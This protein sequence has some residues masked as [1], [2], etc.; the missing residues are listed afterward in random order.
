M[1][2]YTRER[3]SVHGVSSVTCIMLQ[4]TSLD[5]QAKGKVDI[6]QWAGLVP[7]NS[8][9]PSTLGA[10]LSAGAVG[11]KGFMSSSGMDDFGTIDR[12]VSA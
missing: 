10:M 3:S 2:A 11:L 7:H 4:A 9:S 8:H 6:A 5:V 12:Y 1:T